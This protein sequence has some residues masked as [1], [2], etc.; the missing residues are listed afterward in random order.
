MENNQ[1]RLLETDE[2][3]RDKIQKEATYRLMRVGEMQNSERRR[4]FYGNLPLAGPVEVTAAACLEE[5]RSRSGV[6][7]EL[8]SYLGDQEI[9]EDIIDSMVEIIRQGMGAEIYERPPID[10]KP[11]VYHDEKWPHYDDNEIRS[12]GETYTPHEV[13]QQLFDKMIDKA[14]FHGQ[15]PGDLSPTERCLRTVH[16]VINV[17]NA[18]EGNRPDGQGLPLFQL[19][20]SPHPEY[21]EARSRLGLPDYDNT[22]PVDCGLPAPEYQTGLTRA[23]EDHFNDRFATQ[24][25]ERSVKAAKD[26]FGG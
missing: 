15:E 8:E 2:V 17:I 21:M 24:I 18:G 13:R 22:V 14:I 5:L 7:N 26:L 19:L 25:K 12:S 4:Y 3:Y 10:N 16:S 1:P 11:F 23:F 9:E 6:G 20:I